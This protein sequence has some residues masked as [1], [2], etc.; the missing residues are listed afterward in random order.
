[1]PEQANFSKILKIA[2]TLLAVAGLGACANTQHKI[3]VEPELYVKQADFGGGKRISL[4]VVDKRS[5]F[6]VFSRK[7]A[8]KFI[9][10]SSLQTVTIVSRSSI[11]A[12]IYEKVRDALRQLGFRPTTGGKAPRRLLLEVVQ[13]RMN[14]QHQITAAKVHA[15]IKTAIRVTA[16]NGGK[17]FKKI[18]KSAM[19]KSGRMIVGKFKNEVF[20]NNGLSLA[21]QKIFEDKRLLIFLA[22]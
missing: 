12:P 2:A 5:Q 19:E 21:L 15:K 4:K 20:V 9:L 22:E 17:Q 8:P 11:S 13:W 7:A 18:Y 16:R 6:A 1:M 14:Y 10:D 3:S